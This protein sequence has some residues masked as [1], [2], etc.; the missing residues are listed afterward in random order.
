MF[1]NVKCTLFTLVWG[2]LLE[3]HPQDIL[4]KLQWSLYQFWDHTIDVNVHV[5]KTCIYFIQTLMNL[6]SNISK[7]NP[8]ICLYSNSSSEH[9]HLPAFPTKQP[10][11][12]HISQTFISWHDKNNASLPRSVKI[13]KWENPSVMPQYFFSSILSYI[14]PPRD[15]LAD[16]VYNSSAHTYAYGTTHSKSRMRFPKSKT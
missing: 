10:R 6:C 9:Y 14:W 1:W 13:N 3:M 15:L 7:S 2:W 5:Q 11:N 12:N 8:H 16:L 4:G